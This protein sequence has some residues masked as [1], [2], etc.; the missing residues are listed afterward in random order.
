MS[1]TALAYLAI[2]ADHASPRP[3]APD[4]DDSPRA[5][6]SV[7]AGAVKVWQVIEQLQRLNLPDADVYV[8]VNGGYDEYGGFVTRVHAESYSKDGDVTLEARP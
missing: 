4:P 6:P 8:Q 3:S 5:G 1:L 7:G 2:Y